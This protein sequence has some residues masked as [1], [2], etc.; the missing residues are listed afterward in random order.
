[1]YLGMYQGFLLVHRQDS[2][3]QWLRHIAGWDQIAFW[4]WE[5]V[6]TQYINTVSNFWVYL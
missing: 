4:E 5:N 1:M 2:Y 3:H 6:N